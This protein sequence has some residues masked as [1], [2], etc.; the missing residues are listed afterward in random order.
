[1][2]LG[3]GFAVWARRQLGQYWSARVALAEG[4]QLIQTGPY[5]LVRHPIYLGGLVGVMGTAIVIGEMR[6]LLSVVFVLAV[7]V[8]K[9]RTEEAFLGERFGSAYRQYRDEVKALIPFV[10]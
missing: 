9:I 6:G 10:Y 4:H 3:T 7:V 8:L 5:H 2:L 1:M